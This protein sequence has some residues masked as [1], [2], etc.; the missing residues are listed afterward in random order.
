MR[1][2]ATLKIPCPLAGGGTFSKFLSYLKIGECRETCDSLACPWR[3]PG[4]KS[5][6]GRRRSHVRHY[7]CGLTAAQQCSPPCGRLYSPQSLRRSGTGTGVDSGCVGAGSG[8]R[9]NTPG[10]PLSLEPD[11][12]PGPPGRRRTAPV[13]AP[14]TTLPLSWRLAVY[15]E[16]DSPAPKG[17]TPHAAKAGSGTGKSAAHKSTHKSGGAARAS[18]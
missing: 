9:W 18:Q 14:V 7:G 5:C 12:W 16:S 4:G 6:S 17:A 1:H 15:T 3:D 11:L 13:N 8:F 2:L 10:R